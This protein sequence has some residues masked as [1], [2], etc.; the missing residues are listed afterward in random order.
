MAR[1]ARQANR[2]LDHWVPADGAGEPV[3]CVATTFTF[4]SVLLKAG[5]ACAAALVDQH[6]CKGSRSLRWDLVP[7]RVAGGIM[8]AKVSLL[9][10]T[11]LVRLIVASANVTPAG[12][13]TNQEIFGVVMCPRKTVRGGRGGRGGTGCHR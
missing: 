9:V 10:W 8:H 7:V 2:L 6:H 12:Y 11:R 4:D 3:G 5:L 1:G 13:R